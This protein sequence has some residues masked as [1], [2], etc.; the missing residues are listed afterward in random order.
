MFYSKVFTVKES[1]YEG[2]A[3]SRL[4][5]LCLTEKK[6]AV[7]EDVRSLGGGS[8]SLAASFLFSMKENKKKKKYQIQEI[9][10]PHSN[11]LRGS[12]TFA[13]V[14]SKMSSA[15]N[16]C[17]IHNRHCTRIKQ[18]HPSANGRFLSQSRETEQSRG[19]FTCRSRL[20]SQILQN[21]AAAERV[22]FGPERKATLHACTHVLVVLVLLYFHALE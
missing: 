5:P 13:V 14:L 17:E 12:L 10:T 6:S 22:E 2:H 4:L 16:C 8:F 9:H 20:R 15:Q 11:N 18:L 3:I 7:L 1:Y 21:A 19:L